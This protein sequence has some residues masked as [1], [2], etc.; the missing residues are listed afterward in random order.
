M[1]K[2]A[3]VDKFLSPVI[4][5]KQLAAS[6][7][8]MMARSTDLLAIPA[9]YVSPQ[10]QNNPRMST[11]VERRSI[12]N[13]VTL[14][15]LW[16]PELS[17]RQGN[18]ETRRTM[19]Q[20]DY[21]DAPATDE[22]DELIAALTQQLEYAAEQLDRYQRAGAPAAS[23]SNRTTAAPAPALSPEL[24]EGLTRFLEQWDQMQAGFTLGRIEVQLDEIKELVSRAGGDRA[25][26]F[27]AAP[28]NNLT[29]ILSSFAN[30]QADDAQSEADSHEPNS[31]EQIKSSFLTEGDSD[32]NGF[33]KE[34]ILRPTKHSPAAASDPHPV[35][36]SELIDILGLELPPL[37]DFDN[38]TNEQLEDAIQSRDEVI[39]ILLDKA[40]EM[41]QRSTLD[42]DLT[43]LHGF[44]AEKAVIDDLHDRLTEQ[45]KIAELQNSLE[46]ARLSRE[47]SKLKQKEML[48]EKKLLQLGLISETPGEQMKQ[49]AKPEPKRGWLR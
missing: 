27:P 38:A 20:T 8:G 16:N 41:Y 23:G 22:R 33:D 2:I 7:D 49:T 44:E 15:R 13:F 19:D 36:H 37:V 9:V 17:F 12:W 42:I 39:A 35:D 45:L 29:S 10:I 14:R 6:S 46:R 34:S 32:S 24:N 5:L 21:Y 43:E 1:Q 30:S 31:W 11:L 47:Q 25:A 26:A 4:G 48:I 3:S 18:Q 40:A 28:L